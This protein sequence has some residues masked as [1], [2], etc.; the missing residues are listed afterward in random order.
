M[1]R[2][3]K[4]EGYALSVSNDGASLPEGFDPAAGKGTGMRIIRSF[5]E[6]IG[7]ALQIGRNDNNQ[8]TRFT[9]QFS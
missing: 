8:E 1:A 3:K 6:R 5:I 7:G 2:A 4:E 9:V